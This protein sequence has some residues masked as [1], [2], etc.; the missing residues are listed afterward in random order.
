MLLRVLFIY[1]EKEWVL[2]KMKSQLYFTCMTI[3][4]A[5]S[6]LHVQ[7]KCCNESYNTIVYVLFD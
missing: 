4:I 2:I 1:W 7:C 6:L 3:C 5:D